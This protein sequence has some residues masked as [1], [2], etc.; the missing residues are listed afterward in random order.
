MSTLLFPTDIFV[1]RGLELYKYNLI[2]TDNGSKISFLLVD[3]VILFTDS[4]GFD[5]YDIFIL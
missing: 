3:E 1:P 4:I 5:C 2:I